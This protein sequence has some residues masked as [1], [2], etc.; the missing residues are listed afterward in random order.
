MRDP[1]VAELVGR[2]VLRSGAVGEGSAPEDLG[3]ALRGAH[4]VGPAAQLERELEER[5]QVQEMG[6][7][8][9]DKRAEAASAEGELVWVRCRELL[10]VR[11]LRAARWQRTG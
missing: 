7:G 11:A 9:L 10:W 4:A 8:D 2:R 3:E 6:S 1:R 5:R